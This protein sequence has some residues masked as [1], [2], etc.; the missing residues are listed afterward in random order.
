MR[1]IS[2]CFKIDKRNISVHT[3]SQA[4]YASDEHNLQEY[5]T[6]GTRYRKDCFDSRTLGIIENFGICPIVFNL[7][8]YLKVELNYKYCH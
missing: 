4:L 8:E 3:H 2:V 5:K 7:I 6:C 1:W